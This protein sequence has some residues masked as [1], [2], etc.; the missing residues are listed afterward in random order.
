MNL[1]D[2]NYLANY[3]RPENIISISEKGVLILQNENLIDNKIPIGRFIL[4]NNYYI[5]H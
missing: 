1:S 2:R 5:E 3:G 4:D